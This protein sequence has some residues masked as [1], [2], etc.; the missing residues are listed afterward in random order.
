MV[1]NTTV[2]VENKQQKAQAW[3]ENR[4]YGKKKIQIKPGESLVIDVK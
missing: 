1:A 4:F 2:L 3:T